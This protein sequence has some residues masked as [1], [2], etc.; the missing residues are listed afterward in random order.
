MGC[1]FAQRSEWAQAGE[2]DW[3]S[4]REP[5]RAGM[6]RLVRDLNTLYRAEA[7]LH[8]RDCE[9]SGFQWLRVNDAQHS[10]FAWLRLGG[11]EDPPVA[12]LC[13]FTPVERQDWRI[14][15]PRPG[16]WREALNTD[17][18][19]YGGGDRGNLGAVTARSGEADGQPYS[20]TVTLPPLS[21]LFLVFAGEDDAQ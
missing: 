4:A 3:A 13:N 17:A 12:V 5:G 19:I 18:G 15:L 10:V 16:R 21:A 14:G 6:S 1:E 9:A 8:C 7:A 20:A 11:P 2:L